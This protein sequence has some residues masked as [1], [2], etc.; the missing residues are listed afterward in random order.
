MFMKVYLIMYC[1]E[2]GVSEVWDV[3]KSE[4]LALKEIENYYCKDCGY[5][6]DAFS[7]EP[8]EVT[9]K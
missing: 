5:S 3:Y 4:S 7:I 9:E 6:R 1:D 8:W 2:K